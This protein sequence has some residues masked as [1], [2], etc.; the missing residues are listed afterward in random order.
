[1]ENLFIK[2][3]TFTSDWD[4]Y[5]E[6]TTRCKVNMK[7]HEVFDIEESDVNVDDDILIREFVTIDGEEYVCGSETSD[8]EDW[9]EENGYWYR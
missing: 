4:Q 6:I 9:D 8:T 3:A 7:T 1:M 5:G 2:D